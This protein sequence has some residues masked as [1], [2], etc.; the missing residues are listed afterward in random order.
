MDY[1]INGEYYRTQYPDDGALVSW[2]KDSGSFFGGACMGVQGLEWQP[3]ALYIDTELPHWPLS[4]AHEW[5]HVLLA[6]VKPSIVQRALDATPSPLLQFSP[7]LQADIRRAEVMAWRLA[8]TFL[9]PT[10]WNETEALKCLSS[11]W[12]TFGHFFPFD[13]FKII[14]YQA[15]IMSVE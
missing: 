4:L 12:A 15:G 6:F 8:K 3:R 5:G 7:S 2:Q 14:P 11:Y 13:K 10:L 1:S 9:R